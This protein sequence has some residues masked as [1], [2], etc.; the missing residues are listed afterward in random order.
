M[1]MEQLQ[2]KERERDVS[3]D[4]IRIAAFVLVP[5]VHF[6]LNSEY[7]VTPIA[8]M[9]MYLMTVMDSFCMVCVP[10]FLLLTGYLESRRRIAFA[11]DSLLA[12]Y[13][14]LIGVYCVY[15][16]TAI[17]ILAFRCCY[18]GE[19]LGGWGSLEAVLGFQNYSWYVEMY[20][21]LA[22]LI[23]FL[24]AVWSTISDQTGHRCLILILMALTILPS[25]M[26]MLLGHS[27]LP[28]WWKGLYPV[29]Y[30]YL[31]AYLREYDDTAAMPGVRRIGKSKVQNSGRLLVL[32]LACS[33]FA[34]FYAILRNHHGVLTSGDWNDWGSLL[35]TLD[36]VLL[37]RLLRSLDYSRISVNLKRGL[38]RVASLTFA[39]YLLSWIPDH[40]LYPVL[41]AAVP[42]MEQRIRFFLPVVLSSV[43]ISLLLAAI[44]NPLA[45]RI[46]RMVRDMLGK[47][48]RIHIESN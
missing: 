17:L 44:V 32:L 40:V 7:Y 24:N 31:G 12:F 47:V 9:K 36:A 11:R 45:G 4:V 39:A 2:A 18:L 38:E 20:L 37:F 8:G 5:S 21:G 33:L 48:F 14:K 29:T 6:F 41:I 19:R 15:L 26:D 3:L 13:G 43:V 16:V 34:G 23:P 28:D 1:E 27:L 35:N 30:Y 25:A 10:L 46:G 22:L 42:Q